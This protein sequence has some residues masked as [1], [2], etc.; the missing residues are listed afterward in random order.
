MKL[1]DYMRLRN[2]RPEEIAERVGDV[3]T[4]GVRKWMVGERIPRKDQMERLVAVTGGEV[5][6]NDFFDLSGATVPEAAE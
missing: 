2:L 4:S 3:S 1:I 5:L 6:P